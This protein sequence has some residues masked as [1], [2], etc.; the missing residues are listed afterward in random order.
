MRSVVSDAQ[1]RVEGIVPGNGN[2]RNIQLVG[3]VSIERYSFL[4]K[5]LTDNLYFLQ[6]VCVDWWRAQQ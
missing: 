6:H 2:N 4:K 3:P 1:R 5:S